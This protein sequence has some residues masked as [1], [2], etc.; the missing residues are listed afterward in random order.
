MRDMKCEKESSVP[1]GLSSEAS[2][3]AGVAARDG[4]EARSSTSLLSCLVRGG[5]EWEIWWRR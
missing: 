5:R 3:M 4:L 1:L 2:L